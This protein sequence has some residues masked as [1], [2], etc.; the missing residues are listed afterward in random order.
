[1]EELY[2]SVI[3]LFNEFFKWKENNGI[4]DNCP[5]IRSFDSLSLEKFEESYN[6]I[7][8]IILKA[9]FKNEFLNL[10][11]SKIVDFLKLLISFAILYKFEKKY[12]LKYDAMKFWNDCQPIFRNKIYDK[13]GK[14]IGVFYDGEIISVDKRSMRFAKGVTK[15]NDKSSMGIIYKYYLADNGNG[16]YFKAL[17]PV[18]DDVKIVKKVYNVPQHLWKNDKKLKDWCKEQYINDLKNPSFLKSEG[19]SEKDALMRIKFEEN[20]KFFNMQNADFKKFMK[21]NCLTKSIVYDFLKNYTK[22]EWHH[23]GKSGE[24]IYVPKKHGTILAP[25]TGGNKFWCEQTEV[26]IDFN[27]KLIKIN[28]Q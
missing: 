16:E 2:D 23:L 24:M 28:E 15:E 19:I 1:M 20:Q 3:E 27:N 14:K 4:E 26:I 7:K 11:T 5:F 18:F 22:G 9:Q 8:I 10:N 13:D 25:H 12:S 21:D 6:K 17:M